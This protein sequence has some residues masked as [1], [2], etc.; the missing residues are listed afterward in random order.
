MES[1]LMHLNSMEAW[2][3]NTIIGIILLGAFG[4]ITALVLLKI[5]RRMLDGV[6]SPA[7]RAIRRI[8][9]KRSYKK[10]YVVGFLIGAQDS[11]RMNIYLTYH[12]VKAVSL[13]LAFVLFAVL[14]FY[15]TP[16]G[17]ANL[18]TFKNFLCVVAALLSLRGAW[19]E[20]LFLK[21]LYDNALEDMYK[22]SEKAFNNKSQK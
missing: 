15:F 8:E 7:M 4:S 6:L 14:F 1:F 17:K 18:L 21:F 12:V 16:A 19:N 3:K 11:T 10:A 13:I 22:K 5:L 2:L 9:Y 20:Y